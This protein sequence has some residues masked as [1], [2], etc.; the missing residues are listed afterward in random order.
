MRSK[1]YKVIN[2]QLY[3]ID[4]QIRLFAEADKIIAPYGSNLANII[5]CK[6]GAKI[7]EIGPNLIMIMKKYLMTDIKY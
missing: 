7:F 3:R 4:Q 1:G 5:F 2:P 6:P